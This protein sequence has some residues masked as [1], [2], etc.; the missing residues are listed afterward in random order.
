MMEHRQ[1]LQARVRE[2]ESEKQAFLKEERAKH[3]AALEDDMAAVRVS[4]CARAI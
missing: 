2:L 4:D 3:E 1:V